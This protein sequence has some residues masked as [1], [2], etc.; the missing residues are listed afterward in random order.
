MDFITIADIT[1]TILTCRDC[2]IDYANDYLHRLAFSFSLF[3]SDIQ[4]PTLEG[5]LSTWLDTTIKPPARAGGTYENYSLC[6]RKACKYLGKTALNKVTPLQLSVLFKTLQQEENLS[7]TYVRMIH[8][9][10]RAAFNTA[11]RWGLITKNPCIMAD[12]PSPA[13]SPAVALEVPGTGQ[14]K[15]GVFGR[16]DYPAGIRTKA[17]P[18]PASMVWNLSLEIRPGFPRPWLYSLP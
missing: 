18:Q 14:V 4:M 3:D 17:F 6:S 2:D 8:R 13:P 5:F 12:V 16:F 7:A 1:D 15:D 11:I 10:L 9:V